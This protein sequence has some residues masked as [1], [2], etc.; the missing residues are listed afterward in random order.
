MSETLFVLVILLRDLFVCEIYFCL[1]EDE[2][3]D[4][5]YPQKKKYENMYWKAIC[6]PS[7]DCLR[8]TKLTVSDE[9]KEIGCGT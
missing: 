1:E 6:S 7:Y 4:R 9:T 3:Y 2:P 8:I 5:P